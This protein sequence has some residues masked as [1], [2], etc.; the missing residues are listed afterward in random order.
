MILFS[1]LIK[2]IMKLWD[3]KMKCCLCKK[4][5]GKYGNNARPLKDG[6]CCDFCNSTKV[7]PARLKEIK[8]E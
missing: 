2:F 3:N 8:N 6:I 4:E 1:N 7:I 5:A